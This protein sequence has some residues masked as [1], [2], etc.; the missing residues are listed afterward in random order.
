MTSWVIK[1]LT[2]DDAPALAR[3]NMSAFWT[4]P[5]WVILWPGKK[6]EYIIE[7]VVKRAP[8]MLIR[9]REVFRHQKAVDPETGALMGYARWVLPAEVAKTASGDP[10][11]PEAQIPAVSE[12]ER[13]EIKRVADSAWWKPK[14]VPLDG[15]NM[16]ASLRIMAGKPH[17]SKLL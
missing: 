15:V 16:D 8:N 13:A 5:N 3:N 7:Q 9:D 11:W 1:G 6:L 2:L 12:A 14:D 4:D 17:L 10:A